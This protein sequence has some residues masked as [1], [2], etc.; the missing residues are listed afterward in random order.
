LRFGV[1]NLVLI[2]SSGSGSCLLLSGTY[3]ISK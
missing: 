2:S 1:G 3:I